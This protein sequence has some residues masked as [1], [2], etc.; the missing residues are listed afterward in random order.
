MF[1]LPHIFSN[2]SC[3]QCFWSCPFLQAYNGISELFLF[4]F[5]WRLM[6]SISLNV[7]QPFRFVCCEFSVYVCTPLFSTGLFIL[8]MTNFLSPLF[9]LEI[10]PMSNVGLVKIFSHSIGC[11][12]VFLT[13]SF[14]LQNLL[15]FRRSHLLI[16]GL[17]ICATGVIYRKW[18]AVPMYWSILP[19]FFSIRFSVVGFMLRTWS[20]W[21]WIL[22]MG[23][24]MD[25]FSFFY[26]LIFS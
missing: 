6:M 2:I 18:S 13:M 7:F 16:V 4:A 8:L 12:F 22:C 17:S 5:R 14:A 20:I 3:H 23:I 9:I 26:M 11:R 15:S 24:Y 10:S 21:T 25:L 1:P 19:N